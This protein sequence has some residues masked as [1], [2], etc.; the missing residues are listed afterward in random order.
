MAWICRDPPLSSRRGPVSA[1]EGWVG[2]VQGGWRGRWEAACLAAIFL[3]ALVPLLVTPII[4]TIDLYNHVARYFVMSHLGS[5]PFLA[6][7]YQNHWGLLPN[8]GLDV[9]AVVL[10]RFA[11]PV[12]LAKAIVALIFGVQF[13]GAVALTR[14]LRSGGAA[15]CALLTAPLL[16]NFV[17]TWGFANFLL[18]LGLVL[19]A[20]A[21]WI[22][23]RGR[24][25]G[26]LIFL[27]HGFA[28]ALYGSL[29]AALELHAFLE[30]GERTARRA[31]RLAAPVLLQAVAPAVLFMLSRTVQAPGGVTNAATAVARL[32]GSG[33]L[34]GRLTDLAAYR[35]LT[36]VRVERGPGVL[37]DCVTFVIQGLL[38]AYGLRRGALRFSP[39]MAAPLAAGG[40]L[41][42]ITPP[43]LFG[44][45]HISDRIP[46]LIAFL[47]VGAVSLEPRH[48]DVLVVAGGLGVV[49]VLRV[50]AIATDWSGYSQEYQRFQ[51]VAASAPSHAMVA[52]FIVGGSRPDDDRR[53]CEMYPPLL[54]SIR[55][56]AVDLFASEAAQ[57][58]RLVGPLKAA[59]DRL[60][61]IRSWGEPLAAYPAIIAGAGPAGFD[62]VLVCDP[63]N[64]AL[65]PPP[66][67]V[68]SARS[69]Q[70][71][72]LTPSPHARLRH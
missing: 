54:S 13:F 59:I 20:L 44:I 1:V 71:S 33:G 26:P 68:V 22:R 48:R 5:D 45:G 7:N 64:A 69:G 66:G 60:P 42:L 38:L 30:G 35:L 12:L 50:L 10:A 57:P 58:F 32:A 55:G 51:Q 29:I 47:V 19:W 21:W 8:I 41:A 61:P 17:L 15:F 53:R 4:P 37:F 25:A 18:G 52:S 56:D 62:A 67:M 72:L 31:W 70:F 49:T 40:V 43:A 46:V 6:R 2:V 65:P 24:S 16:Y 27:V 9:I 3:T 34:A 14:A 23:S 39:L 63:Q 11:P 28:F 36:F